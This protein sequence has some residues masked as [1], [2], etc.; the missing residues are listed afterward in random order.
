MLSQRYNRIVQHG[1]Q[2]GSAIG[3]GR[4]GGELLSLW[5]QWQLQYE[6]AV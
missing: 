4:V 5:H 2:S 1:T 6:A 3:T